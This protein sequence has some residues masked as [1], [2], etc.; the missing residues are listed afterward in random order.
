MKSVTFSKIAVGGPLA[1]LASALCAGE[2]TLFERQ[3]FQGRR[4]T[5][6]GTMSDLDRT[7]FN[8]RAE[9]II[10]REGVWEV[11][12]DAR[13]NGRCARLQP[14][15]YRNLQGSLDRSIS[16]VREVL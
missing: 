14:G 4:M 7:D 1:L 11:C 12:S 2:I 13:F 5:I 16:S 8:D 10:V 6:R 9:S 3:D 15:E